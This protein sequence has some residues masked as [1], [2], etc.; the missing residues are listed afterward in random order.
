MY[1]PVVKYDSLRVLLSIAAALDLELWQLDVKTAFLYGDLDEEL[2][3][4][5]PEGFVL[6]GQEQLVCHL[7]KPMDSNK[8]H[9]N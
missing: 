1:A 5:Q 3:F 8:P 4:R 2:L 6:P 7:L 9:A